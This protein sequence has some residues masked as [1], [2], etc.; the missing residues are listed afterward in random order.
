[1]Q[2]VKDIS[3]YAGLRSYEPPEIAL[4]DRHVVLEFA[5]MM[6]MVKRIRSGSDWN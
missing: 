1:M 4:A 2:S 6:L 5:G 3:G